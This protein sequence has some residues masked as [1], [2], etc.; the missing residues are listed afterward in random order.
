MDR[1]EQGARDW[2]SNREKHLCR[3]DEAGVPGQMQEAPWEEHAGCKKKSS[4]DN[5]TPSPQERD[6]VRKA[7]VCECLLKTPKYLCVIMVTA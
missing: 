6:T 3:R 7:M 5:T 1:K 4:Q 2:I